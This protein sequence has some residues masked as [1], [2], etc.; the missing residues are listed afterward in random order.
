MSS[1]RKGLTESMI[2][3][4]RRAHRHIDLNDEPGVLFMTVLALQQRGLLEF[5]I[6]TTSMRIVDARVTAA[7]LQKLM[8][9]ADVKLAAWRL[10][11]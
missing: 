4:L 2:E 6:D 1:T 5:S 11:P 10:V 8:E 3:A 9:T 7:G